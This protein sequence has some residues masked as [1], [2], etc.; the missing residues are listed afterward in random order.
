MKIFRIA[1]SEDVPVY[2]IEVEAENMSEAADKTEEIIFNEKDIEIDIWNI[3][4][5]VGVSIKGKR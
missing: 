1:Y 4:E 3:E 5:K 2:D